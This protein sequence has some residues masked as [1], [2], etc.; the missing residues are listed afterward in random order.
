MYSIYRASTSYARTLGYI[1]F[2]LGAGAGE[3]GT[4]SPGPVRHSQA[5][6]SVVPF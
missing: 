4:A 2:D 6:V 5:W 3:P 1:E